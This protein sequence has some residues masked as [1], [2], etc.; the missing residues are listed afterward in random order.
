MS[1]R[2]ADRGIRP[3]LVRDALLFK[4]IHED[5]LS[6]RVAEYREDMMAILRRSVQ[7]KRDN[8]SL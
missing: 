8:G 6:S 4:R 5:N 2:A 3:A 7:R 1:A